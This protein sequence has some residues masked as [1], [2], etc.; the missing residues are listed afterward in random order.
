MN[1]LRKKSG[2]LQ[3]E[4]LPSEDLLTAY[5]KKEYFQNGCGSYEVQYSPEELKWV[6]MKEWSIVEIMTSHAQKGSVLDIGCGE[7]FFLYECLAQGLDIKGV[8]FSQYGIKK[9]NPQLLK[10]FNSYNIYDYINHTDNLKE[11][12]F[13]SLMNVIEH[14][15]N[16]EKLLNSLFEKMNSDAFLVIRFPND[17]SMLHRYIENE[18]EIVNDWWISY[19][20]HIS[21]FNANNMV[22]VL[23]QAGFEVVDMIAEHPIDF[24]L[25][26]A[27]SD[28]IT[29]LEKGKNTH[30][31]R[32]LLDN[33]LFE[34]DKHKYVS[35]LKLYAEMGVGR[36]LTYLC[37]KL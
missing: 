34:Q 30:Q 21:Y 2:Y 6:K 12:T 1:L 33:F 25:L 8:D 5:Y 11:Y 29:D 18:T 37:K 14:V 10:Y 26:N 28:Y 15:L 3:I 36:N 9:Q 32:V 35:I 20:A 27:N 24:N 22:T 17:D 13:V 31:F 23:K 16:P 7:G 4:N 19:P